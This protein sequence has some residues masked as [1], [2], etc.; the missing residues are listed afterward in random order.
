MREGSKTRLSPKST[1]HKEARYA[2][3]FQ[4]GHNAF[5]FLIEFGQ[6][7]EAGIHTRIYMS[8]Q[9]ARIL[10]TLL[11]DTLHQHELEFGTTGQSE[12]RPS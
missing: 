8:P 10:S 2:N 12:N 3:Y 4:V 7:D 5:E 1:A 9:H 11:L 6:R